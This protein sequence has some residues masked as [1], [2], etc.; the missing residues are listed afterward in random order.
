MRLS[1][2]TD[3]PL[4]AEGALEAAL[5]ARAL[6][7][8]APFGAVYA[9]PLQRARQTAERI[10]ESVRAQLLVEPG[11]REIHCGDV[12]GRSVEHVRLHHPAAWARNAGERDEDFRWPGGESYREFRARCLRAARAIASRHRGER[13][14]LVTHA[15][16]ISQVLGWIA[17]VSCARWSSFRPRNASISVIEWSRGR[18]EIVTF[19]EHAHVEQLAPARA[20]LLPRAG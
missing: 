17:G 20:T 7:A 15:G 8:D 9:S 2:W 16:F 18:G 12:D 4:S 6:C 3:V 14:L 5:V 13:V 10:R 19:D 11:L 1:G